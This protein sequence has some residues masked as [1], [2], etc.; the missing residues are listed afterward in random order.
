MICVDPWKWSKWPKFWEISWSPKQSRTF[1]ALL[2]KSLS[3]S[4]LLVLKRRRF[5][6]VSGRILDNQM[7]R[8]IK[9][10]EQSGGQCFK[11]GSQLCTFLSLFEIISEQQP[12]TVQR[13]PLWY[14]QPF[15]LWQGE[16]SWTELFGHRNCKGDGRNTTDTA[17][18]SKSMKK[19]PTVP[20]KEWGLSAW[21]DSLGKKITLIYSRSRWN[22]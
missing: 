1:L 2:H 19:I 8:A 4:L 3:G 9:A 12:Q 6:S 16:A 13:M 14:K 15:T 21:T 7:Q 11:Y 18:W 20:H 17:L 22:G 5:E 10:R